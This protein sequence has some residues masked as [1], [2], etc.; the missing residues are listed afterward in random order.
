M[1][2]VTLTKSRPLGCNSSTPGI[3]AITVGAYDGL[4]KIVKD[5]TGVAAIAAQYGANTLAR[6]EVKNTTIKY[7]ENGTSG[8][9]NRSMGVKGTLNAI[10]NVSPGTDV[11]TA[12]T[13]RELMKGP[14]VLF[15][16]RKDGTIVVAGSQL[17][18]EVVTADSDTGGT[19]GDLNGFTIGFATDEPDF[20]REYLLSTQARTDYAAAL[21]AID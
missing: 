19:T 13:V 6:F 11:D 10:L 9:D 18:A 21:L 8:G 16:E 17:G 14:L 20:S 3:Q 2:C 5:N 7:L 1:S 12:Q 4:N 15:I